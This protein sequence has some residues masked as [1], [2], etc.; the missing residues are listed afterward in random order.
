MDFSI[1]RT[2]WERIADRGDGQ[3]MLFV[4][5]PLGL[6]RKDLC[7][8][9]YGVW[10]QHCG[11]WCCLNGRRTTFQLHPSLP[12]AKPITGPGYYPGNPVVKD[13]APQ[14]SDLPAL[15]SGWNSCAKPTP[16]TAHG[17]RAEWKWES[18]RFR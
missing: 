11:M 16:R 7:I 6:D 4:G 3:N 14:L 12:A 1:D 8:H 5:L 10:F 2:N 18:M 15:R 17:Q 9:C 13:L